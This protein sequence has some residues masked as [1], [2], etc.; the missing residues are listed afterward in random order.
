MGRALRLGLTR[1]PS[2]ALAQARG[3]VLRPHDQFYKMYKIDR[4]GGGPK[5]VLQEINK[6][7]LVFVKCK[8]FNCFYFTFSN[9]FC[10]WMHEV[11]PGW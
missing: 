6:Q 11:K 7:F 4:K 9:N 5:I 3:P 10:L 1:G 8:V 2:A